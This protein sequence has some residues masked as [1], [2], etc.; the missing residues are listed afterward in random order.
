MTEQAQLLLDAV[1]RLDA[2]GIPY[3]LTGSTALSFYGAL[4]ATQ[5]VDLVIELGAADVDRL[6]AAFEPDYECDA[7][8][9]RE[10]VVHEKLFNVIHVGSVQ[11]LDM[12]I[13]KASPYRREEF[14]RRRRMRYEGGELWVVAPEDLILSKLVWGQASGSELQRRDVKGV[15]QSRIALDWDYLLKWA[16][17]LDVTADLQEVSRDA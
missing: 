6:V 15:L 13:R 14:S 5:D 12:V 11:K 1:G 16:A 10:A 9:V 4:R 3:M 7:D 2:L 8:A 17:E